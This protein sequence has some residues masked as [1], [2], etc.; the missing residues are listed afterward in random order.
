[1]SKKKK[2]SGSPD[3]A[4]VMAQSLKMAEALA[5]TYAL[6]AQKTA[7]VEMQNNSLALEKYNGILKETEESMKGCKKAYDELTASVEMTD[8]AI[9]AFLCNYESYKQARQEMQMQEFGELEID[10]Q[11]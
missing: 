8:K 4:G 6:K 7:T 10:S 11:H 9:K 5:N 3:W 2:N 1:M